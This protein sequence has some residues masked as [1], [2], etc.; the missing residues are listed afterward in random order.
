MRKISFLTV[1][2]IVL[3][4][5]SGCSLNSAQ[6]QLLKAIDN[7][8]KQAATLGVVLTDTLPDGTSVTEVHKPNSTFFVDSAVFNTDKS[9]KQISRK[10][11]GDVL[12]LRGAFG[13]AKTPV[14]STFDFASTTF[15]ILSSKVSVD[16]KNYT[17]SLQLKD[18]TGSMGTI[19][20]DIVFLVQD[21]LVQSITLQK[22]LFSPDNPEE[23]CYYYPTGCST[24]LALSYD[25]DTIDSLMKQALNLYETTQLHSELTVSNFEEIMTQ[26]TETYGQYTSW[27]TTNTDQSAGSVFDQAGNKGV[28]WDQ[29]G[30]P[31]VNFDSTNAQE[32][33]NGPDRGFTSSVFF[34]TTDGGSTFFYDKV[35]STVNGS[36][37][38][39]E[40]TNTD[41]SSVGSFTFVN[42][43]LNSFIDN[44]IGVKEQYQV[45][46]K[47]DL[48]LLTKKRN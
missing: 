36:T 18:T 29:Y 42:G 21:D 14:D 31:S 9:L 44:S 6:P 17:L 8:T 20:T 32:Y 46:P 5:L 26:M 19:N 7:T 41:G 33:S 3:A 16:K 12:S 1:S 11:P 47:A 13:F 43:L 38:T 4:A 22:N 2:V 35:L 15:K 28:S 27:T 39:Y 23:V 40:I 30:D 45:S 24:Q 37:T 25:R 10:T 48:A 34:D